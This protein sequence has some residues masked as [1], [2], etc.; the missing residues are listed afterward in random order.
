MGPEPL[1]D[2]WNQGPLAYIEWY[3]PLSSQALPSNGLMYRIRKP[4]PLAT[5]SDLP[6]HITG[7]ILP[8]GNIRQSCMLFPVFP[9]D[10]AS[11]PAS[12]TTD[13]VLDKCSFFFI[14]NWASKYSYQT[15]W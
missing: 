15:I 12:W 10:S 5:A 6:K 13:T 3:S 4:E 2:S 11:V 1:P 9:K 7:V 8:I 14:N